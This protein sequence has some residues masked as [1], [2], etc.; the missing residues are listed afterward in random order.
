GSAARG[1]D[2]REYELTDTGVLD[3]DRF[4]DV[5]VTHAKATA[6]DVVVE[7]S[8]TN[9][10][11]D[12]APLDLVPQG[13]FRN[14]WAWGRDDRRPSMV[15]RDDGVVEFEHAWLGRYEV[16]VLPGSAEGPRV[17]FCDN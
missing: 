13:W 11:P 7:V 5:Q 12:A 2:D 10:G 16:H 15:R 14:T 9:H 3:D 8:A 6:T 17:L 4:F 1:R